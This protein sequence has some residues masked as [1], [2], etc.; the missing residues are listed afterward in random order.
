MSSVGRGTTIWAAKINSYNWGIYRCETIPGQ[1]TQVSNNL[2]NTAIVQFSSK[3]G[4]SVGDIIVIRYVNSSIDGVYRVLSVPGISTITISY[5]F[6]KS[7]QTTVYANGIAFYLQTTRVAQ[8]SDVANLP[9]ATELAFDSL[10]WVDNNGYG[11]WEVLSKKQPFDYIQSF[12]PHNSKTVDSFEYS[13]GQT[14]SDQVALVGIPGSNNGVGTVDVYV[15]SEDPNNTKDQPYVFLTEFNLDV[16]GTQSFGSAIAVGQNTMTAIGANQSNDGMGYVL[17]LS[18]SSSTGDYFGDQVL[19]PPLAKIQRTQNNQTYS[20][21]DVLSTGEYGS[22]IDI[23]FNEQWLYVGAPAAGEVVAYA[24]VTV[25]NESVT[26]YGNK[27]TRRFNYSNSV[28]INSQFPEQLLVMV[29]GKELSYPKDYLL[30]QGDVVLTTD[31]LP[32]SVQ[33]V[34]ISRRTLKE[35]TI[36]NDAVQSFLLISYLYSSFNIDSFTVKLGTNI[37][38]QNLDYTFDQYSRVLTITKPITPGTRVEVITQSYWQ[39]AATINA[40]I[41]DGRF[42]QSVS[43]STTGS[44]LVVG[45]PKSISNRI[46]TGSVYVYDRLTYTHQ[47]VDAS[48]KIYLI[49]ENNNGP[50]TVLVNNVPLTNTKYYAN[51][52][53]TVSGDTIVI[54]PSVNLVVGDNVDIS[55]TQFKFTQKLTTGES[56][57]SDFGYCSDFSPSNDEIFIGAPLDGTTVDEAGTVYRYVNQSRAYGVTTTTVANPMLTTGDSILVNGMVVTVPTNNTVAGLVDAIN[58]AAIPNVNAEVTNNQ[59]FTGNGVTTVFNVGSIYSEAASY[60]TLVLFN[61]QVVSSDQYVYDNDLR[62]IR[63]NKAPANNVGITVVSGRMTIA[64]KVVGTEAQYNKNAEGQNE[65]SVIPG[66]G[67]S[68]VQ[69]GFNTFVFAQNITSPKPTS[70]A[71]FGYSLNINKISKSLVVGCPNGDVYEL[72]SFDSGTTYFDSKSTI[73]SDTIFGSGVAFTYDY[74]PSANSSAINPGKFVFGQQIFNSTLR[75]QDLFGQS[76][77]YSGSSLI[78]GSPS[79]SHVGRVFE[80]KNTNDQPSWQVVHIQEPAVDSHGVNSVY[81]YN[82]T[83]GKQQYYFDC[84]NPLQGKILGAAAQNIDYIGA[85][86]PANYNVGVI[87]NNGDSWGSGQLGAIWWDT[88]TV[89]FI[90]PGQNDINY[91]SRRWGGVFPGSRVDI[92]QWISSNVPPIGYTGPGTPLSTTTYTLESK[93]NQ[94][95]YYEILY[96]FWVRGLNSINVEVGKTLS[97][98]AIAQYIIDPRSS[99]IPYVALMGPSSFAIYNGTGYVSGSDTV[100]HIDY[101]Q[102]YNTDCVHNQFQTVL[103]NDANSFIT[104]VT[105]RKLID[106]FAGADANENPVPDPMLSPGEKYGVQFRPRQSMF[107]DRFGALRNYINSTNNIIKQYPITESKSMLL[108]NSQELPPPAKNNDIINWNQRVANKT[109]L[110]YQDIKNKPNGFKYLVD[111]NSDYKGLWTILEVDHT[112]TSNFKLVQIQ[113]YY[114]PAYWE[115]I[116]WYEPGYDPETET[117]AEVPYYNSLQTLSLQAAPIGSTVRVTNNNRGKWELYKRLGVELWNRVGLQDGTIQFSDYLWNYEAGGFGYDN[118]VFDLSY[119]ASEPLIET[120]N[121]IRAINEEIFVDEM[122]IYR[123][124]LLILTFEYIYSELQA[125]YWLMKTSLINVEHKIRA[126]LPFEE[127]QPDNQTFVLDYINEVKPYHT[128]IKQFNLVYFGEDDSQCQVTDFDC[129]AYWDPNETVPQFVGPMLLPFKQADTTIVSNVGYTSP[130][131]EIWAVEPWKDW[132][133]NYTLSVQT[134]ELVDLGQDYTIPPTVTVVGPCVTPAV[135]RARINIDGQV[136]SLE[137]ESSGQGYTVTPDI[138][139]TG[140]GTG[141]KAV[142]HLSNRIYTNPV[143]DIEQTALFSRSIKTTIKY[144]RYQYAS[145]IIAW[146]P[147]VSYDTGDM[148]R[149]AN[150]VWSAIEPNYSDQFEPLSWEIVPASMLSGV[151]RTMGYYAPTI[152]Q[153]GLELPLLID[154]VEYPGV[155]VFGTPF[156]SISRQPYDTTNYAYGS[157]INVPGSYDYSTPFNIV[158][159]YK[160]DTIYASNYSDLYLGRTYIDINVTGDNYISTDANYAP[161]EL[162]LG[163]TFDTVDIRIYNRPITIID[164]REY[165][166]PYDDSPYS[167]SLYDEQLRYINTQGHGFAKGQVKW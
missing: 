82:I 144:D 8:A 25:P 113:S 107:I 21:S 27:K 106:S 161:E 9:F 117:A 49:P 56:I 84:I 152:N 158:D 122:K 157:I 146:Q 141:A 57:A 100:I 136:T 42:G 22:S 98:N 90:D 123:N 62:V 55:T 151:D 85:V 140:D 155:N 67:D 35:L 105:Y 4:L 137:I 103:T 68:F 20:Y 121:I 80:Y 61:N 24:R 34:I 128:V 125:P 10:I 114:T 165:V 116:N 166:V 74:L 77:N 153:P 127:Y 134:V 163:A 71:N 143:T 5:S 101:D 93:M 33:P 139:F 29:A 108:L 96:F 43:C 115:Y 14:Y 111:S 124:E 47:V 13:L 94:Q 102:N 88:D 76:V 130:T 39:Y 38:R 64:V 97:C 15:L 78:V 31:T 58:L 53:F 59:Y 40:N 36:T 23:S 6:T 11:L 51:G 17:T 110:D 60:N 164:D 83:T 19:I 63:F 41:T 7:N 135:I 44:Q 131:A 12:V 70:S 160:L 45:A 132:F 66:V 81:M 46:N 69:L 1:V 126:L 167:K 2:N 129:P 149:F 26:Y 112:I 54:G 86:D 150:A 75:N 120:R 156:S 148:V 87:H 92:Y 3:H 119:Y 18:L 142:A 32:T 52:Q 50:V 16:E 30:D 73:F 79:R 48:V 138:I 37:L 133:D 99:G 89:R 65:L 118:S 147:A 28:L 72:I 109:I 104:D 95:G 154:G 145:T 159:L 91:T 162:I